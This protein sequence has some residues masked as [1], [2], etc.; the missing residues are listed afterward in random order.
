[1]LKVEYRKIGEVKKNSGIC[2]RKGIRLLSEWRN[3]YGYQ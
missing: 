1:M 2:K 3:S